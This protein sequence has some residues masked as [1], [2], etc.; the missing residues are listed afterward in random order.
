MIRI[1]GSHNS[2]R[3]QDEDR[4]DSEVKVLKRWNGTRPS[5]KGSLLYDFYLWLANEKIKE[6]E[7]QKKI[8]KYQSN[9]KKKSD[10]I[11]WIDKLLQTPIE[12][13]RKNAVSLILAPYL[14]N[15]RKMSIADALIII[16]EWLDECSSLRVLDSNFNYRVK[17]A[18]NTTIENGIP[19]MK[20]DT[21]QQKKAPL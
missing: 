16:K 21:L 4:S 12:D 18:L 5:I 1:P 3:I 2:K 14:I 10:S 8:S 11:H 9:T 20:F 6:T 7:R 13:Y 15:I 19:P 17:Y